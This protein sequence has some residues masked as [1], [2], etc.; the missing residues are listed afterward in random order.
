MFYVSYYPCAT[1]TYALV[2]HNSCS[3]STY[4]ERSKLNYERSKLHDERSK[5]HDERSKFHDER[6]KL[7]D[8]RSKLHDER[9]KLH[10]EI[11]FTMS[12]CIDDERSML[13]GEILCCKVNGLGCDVRTP[14]L[15]L[16][17]H[18]HTREGQSAPVYARSPRVF[19]PF[20]VS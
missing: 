1:S 13:Q 14:S 17:Q 15:A 18:M 16:T 12:A 9:S 4:D 3:T 11:L 5:L 19:A 7:H 2:S 8:E 20:R 10:G 6:S